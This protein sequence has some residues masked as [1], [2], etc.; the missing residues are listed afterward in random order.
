MSIQGSIFDEFILSIHTRGCLSST[1]RMAE[2][3]AFCAPMIKKLKRL[4]G[5]A[6]PPPLSAAMGG[7]VRL[8]DGDDHE[9][10]KSLTATDAYV[11]AAAALAALAAT[12]SGPRAARAA[13]ST[14]SASAPPV[15]HPNNRR[16]VP[17]AAAMKLHFV[18][19]IVK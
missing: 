3:P 6:P 8:V 14:L 2:V 5:S 4:L 7:A 13:A 19:F 15:A 1:Y 11:C 9:R 16:R 12:G 10:M 18:F 17:A